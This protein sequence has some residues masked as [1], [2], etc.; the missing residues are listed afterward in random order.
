M[1]REGLRDRDAVVR[2][3]E[4]ACL[5]AARTCERPGA[6]PPRLDEL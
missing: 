2:A 1:P 6:T 4:F 5:V 3:T